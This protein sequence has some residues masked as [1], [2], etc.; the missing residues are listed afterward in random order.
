[1]KK[2]IIIA[3]SAVILLLLIAISVLLY[4]N[5]P[6]N[7]LGLPYNSFKKITFTIFYPDQ[8]SSDQNIWKIDE[9]KTSYDASSG[10]LSL[11]INNSGITIVMTQQATPAAFKD[12]QQQYPR[13][14]NAL[15]QY[16]EINTNFGAVTLTRPKELNGTQT[17]VSNQRDTLLFAK[18]NKDLTAEEWT[19]FF[20]SL[21]I[22][23]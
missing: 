10:V 20:N 12:V 19:D 6:D 8:G 14:L 2:Q 5:R 11:T 3:I 9:S 17:A 15:Q 21:I 22:L 18:P 16:N 13:M 7:V 23:R 4:I 1:M